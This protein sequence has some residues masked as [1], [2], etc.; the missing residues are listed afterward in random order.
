ML[1]INM[2][3]EVSES[4]LE[5]PVMGEAMKFKSDFDDWSRAPDR[6]FGT[7]V[8]I[9]V[10]LVLCQGN[11]PSFFSQGNLPPLEAITRSLE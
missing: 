2:C 11:S 5:K 8:A 6:S 3:N 9:G 10:A 4:M 7:I 1:I